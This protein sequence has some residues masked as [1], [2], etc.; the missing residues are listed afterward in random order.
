MSR[1][2]V[3]ALVLLVGCG[4]S[5]LAGRV[6]ALHGVIQKAR[7]NGAYKCAPEELAR[8]ESHTAFAELELDEGDYYRAKQEVEVADQNANEAVRKSPKDKCAPQVAIVEPA[9]RLE[10]TKLDSDGD[11]ILDDVDECPKD[12]EDKDDFKDKDGCPDPDNDE[13]G[14]LDGDDKCPIIAE[15]MDNFEDKDGCP[16]DDND[17]D[18]L[19]DAIDQCPNDGED[20]DGFEDD[21]GCPDKDND[22]DKVVDYPTQDDKC[23]NE[24]AA[25]SDGCPQKYQLIVV[26]KDKI[27]LKQT[28]YFAYRKADIK[29]VSFPLLDEVAQAMKD[30]PNIK[31]RIEGHTDS[32]GPDK[33]NL[34]LSQKRAESVRAYLAKKGVAAERMDPKGFGETVPIADNRT[35]AG[36]DQNRRV[37]FVIVSQ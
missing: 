31:V 4:G 37:E 25:T 15:D 14:V 2:L 8:A 35:Q 5:E 27:E 34:K 7:D 3:G 13:D 21:D 30:N 26:K 23:P 32:K 11:G 16:E 12:P 1:L 22:G 17:Q 29:P 33:F 6:E 24:F 9:K 19:V 36:R 18:G 28:I 10:V 20:K